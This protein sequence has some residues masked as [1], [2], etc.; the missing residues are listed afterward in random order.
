VKI[1]KRLKEWSFIWKSRT[2]RLMLIKSVL[3]A[4]LV[5]WMS[6]SWIPKGIL[7]QIFQ[8]CFIFL[9]KGSKEGRAFPWVR[10]DKSTLPK[11]WGGWGLKNLFHFSKVLARK[12]GWRLIDFVILWT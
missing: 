2:R 6:L 4:I 9:W 8:I 10:W 3:E 7:N 1:E 5:F 12:V 11:K